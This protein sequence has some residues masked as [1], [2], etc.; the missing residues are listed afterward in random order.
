M[1]KVKDGW[2]TVN[3]RLAVDVLI[4]AGDDA[5]LFSVARTSSVCDPAESPDRFAFHTPRWVC[6]ASDQLPPSTRVSTRAAVRSLLRISATTSPATVE[7]AAG[8]S[9]TRAGPDRSTYTVFVNV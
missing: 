7:D 9:I 3:E 1:A 4:C 5:P 8:V 6:T 2:V